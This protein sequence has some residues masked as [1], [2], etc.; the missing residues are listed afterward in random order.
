MLFLY[1]IDAYMPKPN[2][3]IGILLV[4]LIAC[5]SCK[6]TKYVPDGQHLLDKVSITTDNKKLS[7]TDFSIY[8]RQRP[9]PK[10]FNIILTWGYTAFRDATLPY[11]SIA[12]CKR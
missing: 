10:L 12:F 5:T 9:N 7:D 3:I 6:V 8:L 4:L 1:V 11:G 2:Y